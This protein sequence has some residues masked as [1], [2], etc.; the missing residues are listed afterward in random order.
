MRQQKSLAAS[1]LRN[2]VGW[3][4]DKGIFPKFAWIRS[5]EVKGMHAS[6]PLR[7]ILSFPE[8]SFISSH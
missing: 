8:L 2:R 6:Q 4:E 7:K 5:K 1:S 3:K